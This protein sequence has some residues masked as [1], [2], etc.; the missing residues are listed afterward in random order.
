[1]NTVQTSN[2]DLSCLCSL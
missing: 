2:H 1:M